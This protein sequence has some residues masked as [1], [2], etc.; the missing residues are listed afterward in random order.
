M[1]L[2]RNT[3]REKLE[4][5]NAPEAEEA[6]IDALDGYIEA[7]EQIKYRL[8]GK[9]EIVREEN[10]QV[11]KTTAPGN[12]TATA[13]VTDRKLLF[14]VAAEQSSRTA[15]SYTEIKGVD[16]TDGLLRSKLTVEVW[17]AGEYRFKIAD[18][19]E[20]GA[21]VQYLQASSQCWDQVIAAL[22][23]VRERTAEMGEQIEAGDLE[24]AREKRQAAT[25]KLDRAMEYLDR[26]DIERPAALRERITEAK[27][28]RNR[29]E[30]R[31]RISRAETLITEATHHTETREYTQAYQKF[32]YARDHLETARSIANDSDISQPPEISTKLETIENRLSHLEVRPRAL[33]QQACERAE[34]TDKL[35][36]EVQA[37]QEAFE[38]YRD[39]LTAGWGT[40][41]EFSGDVDQLRSR[42]E[43]VVETLIERR[44]ELA[45]M[46]EQDGDEH[47]RGHP[48]TARDRYDEAIEQLEA[49]LQLA[50]EFRAGDA[51]ALTAERDRLGTKRYSLQ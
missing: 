50:R 39:A 3:L 6:V 13:I 32:W 35:T 18:S 10:G 45:A 40:E 25:A 1:S 26:F 44:K 43:I 41:L 9:G 12:G 37:W 2:T 34:G 14:V 48:D 11:D 16:A 42:I 23:D 38:H 24:A 31:T 8:P 33:A 5:G 49:A 17:G 7:S 36:V 29:T 4:P 19:S 47:R 20:L 22:D 51:E 28:E 21:A 27:R 30:V 15:I 46:L